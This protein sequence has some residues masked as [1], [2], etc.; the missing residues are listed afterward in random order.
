MPIYTSFTTRPRDFLVVGWGTDMQLKVLFKNQ[1]RN[2][3]TL[4]VV[5]VEASIKKTTSVHLLNIK[6]FSPI[7]H[8][9]ISLSRGGLKYLD[10]MI[11]NTYLYQFH[12]ETT[13]FSRGGVGDRHAFESICLKSTTRQRDFSCG[14][15]GDKHLNY[16]FLNPPWDKEIFLM[17]SW[18]I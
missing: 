16:L 6:G 5:G 10:D 8:E 2:N 13:R 9:T 3:E 18:W 17:V 4:L 11:E 7:H 15:V 12:H 14:G 1:P